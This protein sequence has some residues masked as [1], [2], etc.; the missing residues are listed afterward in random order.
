MSTLNRE[1]KTYSI[2]RSFCFTFSGEC[3][4]SCWW[5]TSRKVFT[6]AHERQELWHSRLSM[7]ERV[8][9][10]TKSESQGA[11]HVEL[12]AK[13]RRLHSRGLDVGDRALRSLPKQQ[14]FYRRRN[15]RSERSGGR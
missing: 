8:R 9:A 12:S 6:N 1:R 7:T 3:T 14:R 2:S 5:E 15:Y 11:A 4:S 10:G 13:S